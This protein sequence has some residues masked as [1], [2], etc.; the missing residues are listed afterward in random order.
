[1]I[2]KLMMLA[3][4]V[5]LSATAAELLDPTTRDEDISSIQVTTKITRA[6]DGKYRYL[7]TLV[8][9][10]TTLGVAQD[11]FFAMNCP[12][13][14]EA[15]PQQ[16]GNTGFQNVYDYSED[17]RH[18][19]IALN[20]IDMSHFD[21]GFDPSNTLRIMVVVQPGATRQFEIVST[22]KPGYL[23]FSMTVNRNRETEYDYSMFGRHEPVS[24]RAPWYPDWLLSGLLMGPACPGAEATPITRPIYSGQDMPDEEGG[25]NELLRY[26]VK[27]NRNRWHASATET[28][29]KLRVYYGD[30]IDKTTFTATLNGRDISSLFA[31]NPGASQEVVIPLEGEKSLIKLSVYQVGA[32]NDKGQLN[33]F[34]QDL[35]PFEIRRSSH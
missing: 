32:K 6:A 4:V 11:L 20:V 35:D 24:P 33:P 15:G 3:L 7:Y 18:V 17:G 2:T 14:D 8:S 13:M 22:A 34:M 5:S 1:M 29:I 30:Q 12:L 21:A 25:V 9:P 10:A 23:P 27:G 19:P 28:S 26:E 31:P 16:A